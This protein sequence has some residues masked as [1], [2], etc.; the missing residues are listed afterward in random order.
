MNKKINIKKIVWEK[1]FY[2][3]VEYDGSVVDKYKNAMLSGAKFPKICVAKW[4]NKWIIVD[5]LHRWKAS[6]AAGLKTLDCE[7]FSYKSEE[8]LY[9]ESIKRN[10]E[11]GN[12]FTSQ[13]TT[14]IIYTLKD[15]SVSKSEISEL[16]HIPISGLS[17]FFVEKLD[18]KPKTSGFENSKIY[19]RA[20]K[21]TKALDFDMR[22]FNSKKSAQQKFRDDID[23]IIFTLND[24]EE[25]DIEIEKETK[26]K[27]KSLKKSV[28]KHL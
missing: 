26:A 7:I 9:F 6:I 20:M 22:I 27:L 18:S 1:K 24:Y 11:H 13:D 15:L 16:V 19:Q 2:P 17:S 3:R 8:E 28:E 21:A 25:Q 5:G 14:K 10:M 4:N 12:P 23:A